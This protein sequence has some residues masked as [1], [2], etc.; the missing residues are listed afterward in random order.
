[1]IEQVFIVVHRNIDGKIEMHYTKDIVEAIC[2]QKATLVGAP[3]AMIRPL[4]TENEV[5]EVIKNLESPNKRD[6][7]ANDE[8]ETFIF[9]LPTQ[10]RFR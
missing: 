10:D 2:L 9:Y 7:V 6:R 1:M 3:A 5:N 4:I 8:G